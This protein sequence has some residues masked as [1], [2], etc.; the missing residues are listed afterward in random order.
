MGIRTRTSSITFEV[1]PPPPSPAAAYVGPGDVVSGSIGW[2]GLRAYSSATIG[3]N[4]IRLRRDSDNAE[5][6]FVTLT[7][8]S[9]DVASITAWAAGANLFVTTLYDQSGSGFDVSQSIAANQPPFNLNVLGS[10]PA[11]VPAAASSHYV[12]ST[13]LGPAQVQPWTNSVV[14]NTANGAQ[15]GIWSH[16]IGATI[17]LGFD[18]GGADNVFMY[19]GLVSPATAVD[20]ATHAIQAIFD[21]ASSIITVDGV[22]T[23]SGDCGASTMPNTDRYYLFS[24]NGTAQFW[25]GNFFEI[26]TW[27]GGFSAGQRTSMDTN[28][29]DY[30]GF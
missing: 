12:W 22:D 30:W 20:G 14:A 21:G 25:S 7:D 13:V 2:W 11:I 18:T 29:H 19:A 26:G 1:A 28:Q 5:S 23:S 27:P 6:N 4:A 17:L 15:S 9:L 8:G 24:L 3:T 10:F 16:G